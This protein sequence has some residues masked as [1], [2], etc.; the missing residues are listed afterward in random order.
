MDQQFF[1]EDY[2]KYAGY[3]GREAAGKRYYVYFRAFRQYARGHKYGGH[4]GYNEHDESKLLYGL[5]YRI[6][7]IQ[8]RD[9]L[10]YVERYEHALYP[11]QSRGKDNLPKS[12]MV[13]KRQGVYHSKYYPLRLQHIDAVL[14]PGCKRQ[15]KQGQAEQDAQHIF[16]YRALTC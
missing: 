3:Y 8:V 4:E 12:E 9:Y 14:D 1:P 5:F 7:N 2:D 15:V 11:Q 10:P 13:K 6:L 16:H